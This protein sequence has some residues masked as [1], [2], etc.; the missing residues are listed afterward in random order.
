ML[1]MS[2]GDFKA[3][4]KAG[5]QWDFECQSLWQAFRASGY[6]SAIQFQIYRDMFTDS[7]MRALAALR[8]RYG[9]EDPEKLIRYL[10]KQRM[11]TAEIGILLDTRNAAKDLAGNRALTQEELWPRNLQAAHDRYTRARIESIDAEKVKKFQQGFD[12]VID[13]YGQLQWTDGELCIILPKSYAELVQEGNV[14][15]HCVGGYGDSHISG[16]DTIF[17]VRKYRR[18]ERNYYTLDI[19]MQDKPYRKQLHGYG[20]ERHGINKQYSHKIPQKVL[21]FCARWEREVLMPWWR[22]NQKKEG[23]TA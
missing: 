21:D 13:K 11:R 8:K 22:D 7:G 12:A 2:K 4:R 20:N 6:T 17:F 3:I 14:L 18:P 16:S 9:E 23:K 19:N 10:K 1:G 15:R 5:K